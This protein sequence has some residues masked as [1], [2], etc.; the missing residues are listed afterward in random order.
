MT[1]AEGKVWARLRGRQLAGYKFRRQVPLGPYFADFVCLRARLVV[2]VDGAGHEDEAADQRKTRYLERQGF[3]VLRIPVQELDES[4]DDVI[5]GIFSRLCRSVEST[6]SPPGGCAA[7][8][9]GGAGRCGPA[10]RGGVGRRRTLC[11]S[12]I[13]PPGGCAADL[14]GGAGRCGRRPPRR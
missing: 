8:L 1:G 12:S 10:G 11:S 9:P 6:A 3:Q 4:L 5:G 7:D 2:E 13:S 14:P